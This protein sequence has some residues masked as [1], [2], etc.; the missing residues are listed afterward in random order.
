MVLATL[1]FIVSL[2]VQHHHLLDMERTRYFPIGGL[3]HITL[4]D[5]L[6]PFYVQLVLSTIIL[7]LHRYLIAPTVLLDTFVKDS[8]I[9]TRQAN[10][11][12][13]IIVLVE[14][15]FPLNMK[16]FLASTLYLV[17]VPLLLV[18]QEPITINICSQ[19]AS[20]VLKDIIV[21]RVG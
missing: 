17:Q 12:V 6:F 11:S 2:A 16:V 21:L 1:D 14:H 10:V 4:L 13:G 20:V 7:E 3:V 19:V 9:H 15:Q 5:L 8:G 18:F